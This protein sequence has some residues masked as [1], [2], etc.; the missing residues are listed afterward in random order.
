MQVVVQL[1]RLVTDPQVVV[2]LAHR[3]EKNHEVGQEDLV[4]AAPGPEHV[5]AVGP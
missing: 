4:H 5:Q 2:T 1:P 3:V